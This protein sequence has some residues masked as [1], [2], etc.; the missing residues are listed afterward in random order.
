MQRGWRLIGVLGVM[1][2]PFWG[3][4]RAQSVSQT[5]QKFGLPGIWAPDCSKTASA[6]NNYVVVRMLDDKTAQYDVMSDPQAIENY[7]IIER[8]VGAGATELSLSHVNKSGRFDFV[9]QF[10]GQR[11]RA[12]SARTSGG[13]AYIENGR[14]LSGKSSNKLTAWL[15]RCG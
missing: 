15:N 11:W 12:I 14:Y 6:Q 13:Q 1:A 8:A 3:D 2:F 9:I 5:L 4:A 10:D 7:F